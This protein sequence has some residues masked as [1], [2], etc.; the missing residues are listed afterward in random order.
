MCMCEGV[1]IWVPMGN[2]S[3]R[4]LKLYKLSLPRLLGFEKR[5]T[6]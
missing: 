1:T 6:H 3:L 5:V 4:A 2:S